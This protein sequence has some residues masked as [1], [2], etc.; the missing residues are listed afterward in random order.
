MKDK[1]HFFENTDC[2][3]TVHAL[4]YGNTRM[5][6]FLIYEGMVPF[7]SMGPIC[8]VSIQDDGR[9][10]WSFSDLTHQPVHFYERA[11]AKRFMEMIDS[12]YDWAKEIFAKGQP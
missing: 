9:A 1:R 7:E 3:Y 5:V 6:S 12:L 8:T 10:A 2:P 11:R 4:L